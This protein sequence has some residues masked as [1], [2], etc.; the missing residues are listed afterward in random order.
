MLACHGFAASPIRDETAD[1]G[2][3]VSG[4]EAARIL[5]V[6]RR[7]VF[8]WSTV[9][10]SK[11]EDAT[12]VQTSAVSRSRHRRL[13]ADADLSLIEGAA[14]TC[15]KSRLTRAFRLAA[16]E[17]DLAGGGQEFVTDGLRVQRTLGRD[18][19]EGVGGAVEV[20]VAVPFG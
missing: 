15:C 20:V 17:A 8:P 4:A 7:T 18:L 1:I 14:Q 2:A 11:L 5:G 6:S 10:N 13:A 3:W 9:T 12:Y 16:A 19:A